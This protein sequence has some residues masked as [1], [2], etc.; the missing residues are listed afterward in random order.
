MKI[1]L[2]RIDDKFQFRSGTNEREVYCCAAEKLQG[3]HQKGQRPMELLLNGLAACLSIDVLSILY[4]QKQVIDD[5]RVEVIAERREEIPSV[6]TKIQIS[7]FVKGEVKES[8]LSRAIHL[9]KEKYCS[10][11]H[12][13]SPE[14]VITTAYFINE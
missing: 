13:L 6:F 14:I 12:S 7:F 4:K 10:A 11:Y 8:F 1:S 3:P 5:F 9:G 2:Q